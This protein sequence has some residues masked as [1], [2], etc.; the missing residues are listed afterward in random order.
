MMAFFV[1]QFQKEES[2]KMASVR[3][4]GKVYEYRFETASVDGTRKQITKSGFRT[5]QEALN[6]GALDYNEYYRIGRVKRNKEMSYAD[7][8]DFWIDTYCN[9]NLKYSTIVTYINI[10]KNDLKPML[11]RYS[12]LQIDT[13]ILQKFINKIYVD[14]NLSK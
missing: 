11:G 2:I 3:K 10:M 9:F 5:K 6:Q 8:L 13:Q 7:Y 4:R 1:Y 14:K 12:L